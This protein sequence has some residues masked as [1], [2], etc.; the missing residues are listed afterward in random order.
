MKKL[1]TI[2]L[3]DDDQATNFIHK[4]VIEKVQCT[5]NVICMQSGQEALDY[6]TSKINDD[7]P[8]PDIIF[9]DINMPGMNGWEFIEKYKKIDKKQKGKKI[10]VMLTTSSDPLD[11]EKA[12]AIDQINKFISKPLTAEAIRTIIKENF[13]EN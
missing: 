8:Q 2:L 7:Y 9:L 13:F 5:E 1:H 3:I 11:K 6:L 10:V 12:K 4:F